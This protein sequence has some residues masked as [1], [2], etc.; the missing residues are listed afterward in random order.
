M[1]RASR[2]LTSL[3]LTTILCGA[4]AAAGAEASARYVYAW[5]GDADEKDSDF[6]AVI[7]ADPGSKGYGTVVATAPTLASDRLA[8][9]H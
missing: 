8:V 6:L 4:A 1:A 7:D 5:A 3:F 2:L 9:V